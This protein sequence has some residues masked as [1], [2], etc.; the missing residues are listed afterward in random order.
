[1]QQSNY[2]FIKENL[3]ISIT[4]MP[5]W[6]EEVETTGDKQNGTLILHTKNDYDEV[7][8]ANGKM[9]IIWEKLPRTEFLHAKEVQNSIDQYNAINMVVTNKEQVWL[10]SH[11]LTIWYGNRSKMIRKH[12]YRENAIH[13]IFYCDITERLFNIHTAVILEHYEGFKP[14]IIDAYNSIICHE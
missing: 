8:G 5:I 13:G 7:W 11:E 12:F 6:F 14:Y 1:M 3:G 10:R 2:A 4:K 9:D